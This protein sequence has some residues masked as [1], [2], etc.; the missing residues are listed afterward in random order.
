MDEDF[1]THITEI[2]KRLIYIF[3]GFLILFLP[4]FHFDN[5]LYQTIAKPLLANMPYGIKLIATDITSPFLVPMKLAGLVALVLSMPNIIYQIWQFLSPGMY[6]KEKK[7]FLLMVPSSI[8]LFVLGN[9]FCYF[10]VFPI[11]FNFIASVK[12]SEINMMTDIGKYLDFVISLLLTF[13]ICFQIPIIIVTLVYFKIVKLEKLQNIRR[14]I[15]VIAF[16]IGAILAPPDI[17]SQ[18]M[19]AIPLYILYEIGM[20]GAK[21]IKCNENHHPN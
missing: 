16:I 9:I 14:Y 13:G 6:N 2:R 11:I 7:I 15:L 19:L 17:I 8:F 1:L 4:L 10:L 21:L 12:S 5:L 3:I 18:T 20:L